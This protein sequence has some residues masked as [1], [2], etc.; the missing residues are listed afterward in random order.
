MD[1]IG[2]LGI[3]DKVTASITVYST[4]KLNDP[5]KP[6]IFFQCLNTSIY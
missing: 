6:R 3:G 2:K 5:Q 4:H 1:A